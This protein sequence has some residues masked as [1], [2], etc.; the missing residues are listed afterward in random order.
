MIN[1]ILIML[2][3]KR[4]YK[5]LITSKNKLNTGMV[6]LVKLIF[7]HM[8]TIIQKIILKIKIG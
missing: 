2:L 5:Q 6:N 7:P 3:K 4:Y 8:T 1:L